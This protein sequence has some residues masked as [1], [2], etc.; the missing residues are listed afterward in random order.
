MKKFYLAAIALCASQLLSA[1]AFW[2]PTSYKGAFPITD[3]TPNTDWTHSWTNWDPENANYGAATQTISSN[4]VT[5][6]TLSG[7]VHIKNNVAVTNN[8]TLTILPGTIIRGD[9][10]TKSC[11][12]IS[13]GSKIMAQ[14]TAANPIVFTT[15]ESIANGR[16]AGD[17]GGLVILGNGIINTACA[18]C[19]N[20][21]FRENYIEGFSTNFPE[22]LYGGTNNTESS[23]ILSYVRIE[24]AGVA[25]SSTPNS[26]INGLTFGGV[27]SGTQV[28]HIQVS[29]SGDDSFEWFGGAVD[30]K[31]LIA[32]R[33]IDDDFDTDF[34]HQGRVQFGLIIRDKD[35]SDAAGDSNGFESDNYSPG[36]GRLPLTKTVFSNVTCIG[37]KRN[38]TVT[39]PG[40]EK[41]ERGIFTRRNTS[42]SIHN[43]IFTGWEK[44]WDLSGA[45]TADNYL[46]AV[47]SGAVQNV[48]ISADIS[49]SFLGQTL[50]TMQTYATARNID[51]TKTTAQ[52]NFVN[53]FPASLSSTPDFR[54][55]AA[56]NSAT[57]ASFSHPSFVGG[58][59]GI[60]EG[61]LS[62]IS[63]IYP[64]PSSDRFKLVLNSGRTEDVTV[65]ISDITGKVVMSLPNIRVNNGSEVVSVSTQD[66]SNGVYFVTINSSVGKETVKLI[67]NK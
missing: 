14:G 33:G 65:N 22:I 3:N 58:F 11:L 61:V 28:D 66:L 1:Q 5:S 6:T 47:D 12:I 31:Y 43:S 35:A 39:L 15:N 20:A 25:L 55:N 38:G 29:F 62:V 17:W 40:T 18:T 54:L 48:D 46:G 36:L 45:T 32:F 4:I 42:I 49:F 8:S 34:G 51:T 60:D 41:F 9:K 50:A 16:A 53:G 64:N 10:S 44:G 30:G 56:S 24:F 57:G 52:I 26:E 7:I 63:A 23:G 59:V 2:T 67:V 37:P 13:R 19:T 21:A 27:G